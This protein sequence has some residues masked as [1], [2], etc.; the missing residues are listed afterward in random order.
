MDRTALTGLALATAGAIGLLSAELIGTAHAGR[1]GDKTYLVA[2]SGG[3]GLL[4]MTRSR[5]SRQPPASAA[6]LEPGNRRLSCARMVDMADVAVG[7]RCR[8]E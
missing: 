3:S 7:F 2:V 4:M 8:S 5:D 1:N 6:V